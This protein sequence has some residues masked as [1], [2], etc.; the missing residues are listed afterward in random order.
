MDT[1]DK[2]VLFHELRP[3]WAIDYSRTHINRL[4]KDGLFPPP[5]QLNPYVGKHGS[6]KAWRASDLRTYR[7]RCLRAG[8]AA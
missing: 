2:W 1:D 5:I 4:I 7:E 6:R 3:D 8:E